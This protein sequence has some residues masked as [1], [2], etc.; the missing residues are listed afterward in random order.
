MAFLFA[1]NAN[2][3]LAGP[4]GT[5]T[6]TANVA[7]GT[8]A[9]F[10]SP[11]GGNSFALT[12]ISASNSLITEIVYCTARTG[13]ALTIVRA[14]EGTGA[15]S[16]NTGDF[17]QNLNTAGTMNAFQQSGGSLAATY[18]VDSGSAN[19]GV[20]LFSYAPSSLAGFTGVPLQVRKSASANSGSYTLAANSFA[21]TT[22]VHGDGSALVAGE[23][24][25]NGVFTVVFNGT[26][27]VLQSV[28]FANPLFSGAYDE[29]G[30]RAING[31]NYTNTTGRPMW[32]GI[33]ATTSSTSSNLNFYVTIGGLLVNSFGQPDTGSN[34]T[35]S[36][37]VPPGAVYYATVTDGTAVLG[38]WIEVY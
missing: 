38:T 10:P 17:A 26:S 33:T 34:T 30:S 9:L 7:T 31:T 3:T 23:L 35:V 32:V 24:P 19:A 5:G 18:A 13:D 37:M 21:A 12:L 22:L 8:G 16:W 25:A 1:N 11:S 29:T 14:R 27:F 28:A 15:L 2:T 20:A 6:T 4:L 36:G